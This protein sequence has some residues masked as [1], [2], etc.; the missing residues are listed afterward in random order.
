MSAA[1]GIAMAS[2][3][4]RARRVTNLP[5]IPVLLSSLSF[6]ASAPAGYRC[7]DCMGAPIPC[8]ECYACF[9]FTANPD[10]EL[11]SETVYVRPG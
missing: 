1:A 6:H 8:P 4:G 2:R 10:R 3:R 5:D 9:W 11:G 7:P